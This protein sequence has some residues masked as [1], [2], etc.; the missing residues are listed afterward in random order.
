M[1][2]R[3]SEVGHY[4]T[5]RR[6][7]E[8]GREWSAEQKSAWAIGAFSGAVGTSEVEVKQI[9]VDK[10]TKK[11]EKLEI[12]NNSPQL[13]AVVSGEV[14]VPVSSGLNSSSVTF[15]RVEAGEAVL[16][17]SKTW[18]AGAVGVDVPADVIVVLKSGTT[19][20]DTVKEPLD[21]SVEYPPS[22]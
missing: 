11:Y 9:C 14:A 20:A 16:V 2:K 12:H 7:P 22:V 4:G 1:I 13:Y 19:E 6:I 10:T 8:C 18:H 15:L 17:N 21:S 3:A 5:W